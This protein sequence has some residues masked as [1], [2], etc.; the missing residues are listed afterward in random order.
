MT[1]RKGDC[2]R[3]EE[4]SRSKARQ[5]RSILTAH[6]M[7]CPYE[8]AATCYCAHEEE[9]LQDAALCKGSNGGCAAV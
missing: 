7:V 1:V 5:M 2:M 3:E 6:L 4:V 8:G 9:E